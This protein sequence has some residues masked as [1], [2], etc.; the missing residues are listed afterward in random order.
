MT[1]LTPPTWAAVIL[2]TLPLVAA[3]TKALWNALQCSDCKKQLRESQRDHRRTL[4]A[5]VALLKK[6]ERMH[7]HDSDPP[8][9]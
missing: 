3:G 2:A 4:R 5:Y 1:D 6:Y 8:P 7:G 9:I